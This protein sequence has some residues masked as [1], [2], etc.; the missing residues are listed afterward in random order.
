MALS[1]NDLVTRS[2][3][4]SVT[5][6]NAV[7]GPCRVFMMAITA[8]ANAATLTIHNA[9]TASGGTPITVGAALTETAVIDFGPTG[10]LFDT[11]LSTA[12]T[13]TTPTSVVTYMVI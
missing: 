3:S 2:R 10:I 11:G 7:A 5:A 1:Y 6:G 9:A 12:T 4:F 13:G 8:G